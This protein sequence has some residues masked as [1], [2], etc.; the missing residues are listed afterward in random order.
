ME[1][2]LSDLLA[3]VDRRVSLTV[4]FTSSYCDSVCV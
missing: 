4:Q 3:I 2:Y 1:K